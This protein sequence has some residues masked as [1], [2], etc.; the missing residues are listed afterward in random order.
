MGLLGLKSLLLNERM[1]NSSE[2]SV[3]FLCVLVTF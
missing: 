2:R 3:I 1:I